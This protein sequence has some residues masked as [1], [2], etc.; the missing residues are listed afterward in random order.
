MSIKNFSSVWADWMLRQFSHAGSN[1]VTSNY[2]QIPLVAII[3]ARPYR[4]METRRKSWLSDSFSTR[5]PVCIGLCKYIYLSRRSWRTENTSIVV[6]LSFMAVVLSQ[7]HT[8]FSP[9]YCAESAEFVCWVSKNVIWR[10][11]HTRE[12]WMRVEC[13]HGEYKLFSQRW[14]EI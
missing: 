13:M 11:A 14:V 8:T 4:T 6:N 7:W 5:I 2:V 10:R 1:V 12:T 9:F 3:M